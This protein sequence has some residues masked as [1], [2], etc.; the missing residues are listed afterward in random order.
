LAARLS[1]GLPP[2]S[3]LA[4]ASLGVAVAL[5]LLAFVLVMPRVRGEA[6]AAYA[7]LAIVGA[8]F[9]LMSPAFGP[10]VFVLGLLCL[11]NAS[12]GMMNGAVPVSAIW[13]ADGLLKM[14]TG[15]LL[16]RTSPYFS[17]A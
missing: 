11:A 14:A 13:A 2:P 17:A 7:S 12:I 9:L 5:E 3:L 10:G 4:L 8:H 1:A 15:F 6:Q 16:L